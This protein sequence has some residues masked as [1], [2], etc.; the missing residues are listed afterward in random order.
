MML[1]IPRKDRLQLMS[2]CPVTTSSFISLVIGILPGQTLVLST[3]WHSRQ[4]EPSQLLPVR[5]ASWVTSP[6][7]MWIL[8]TFIRARR[9]H[10]WQV[11]TIPFPGPAELTHFWHCFETII[12]CAGFSSMGCWVDATPRSHSRT[13][14][15]S[16]SCPWELYWCS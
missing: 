15:H 14:T 12:E 1:R 9:A 8:L 4:P 6:H 16:L 7:H 5:G 13:S 2:T 10:H 11:W 3:V